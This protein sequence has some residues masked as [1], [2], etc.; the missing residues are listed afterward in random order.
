MNR[1]WI[2]LIVL[3]TLATPLTAAEPRA[4][5]QRIDHHLAQHWKADK[6]QPAPLADDAE[7]LRRV[8]LDLTGRIPLPRD[9]HDFLAD[10]DPD[11]R[12]QLVDDLLD[13]PRHS[14]HFA[15][16]WRA[17]LIPEVAAS[18][19][20]RV[21]Q[22][23]FEAWLNQKLRANVSFDQVVKELLSTPI[24]VEQ[25]SP[26]SVLKHPERPN[27]LAF[28]A[29]KDASPA[30][31]AA[32]TTRLFLGIQIECAQCHDHPFASW[33]RE[34]F[35]NQAAFFAG[36]ERQ[37]DGIFAPLSEAVERRE[38]A[39]ADSK[40]IAKALFLD[41]KSPEWK[42]KTSPR[43]ALAAWITT[44]E[45][46]YF[47]K[48]TVNRLWGQLMGRGIV[49]PVDDFNDENKPSH[50]ELLDE[51]AQAFVAAKFD[52][53]FMLRAI[54]LSEAYQRSS[55]R[56][57]ASQDEPR[58]FAKM[59]VKGL[60]GEQF[61]DNLALATGYRESPNDRGFGR[62]RTTIRTQF[63]E[64]FA[65]RGKLSDPETSIL[66][67]LTLM[68]GKFINDATTLAKSPTLTAICEMPIA[69]TTQKIDS[70]YLI[71]FSR[72]PTANEREKLESYVSRNGRAEENRRL[73]DVFWMLLNS[74]EFRLNH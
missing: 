6:V 53:R 26:E 41:Q 21:F 29:V 33:S 61:F 40:K 28:F 34:Q 17:L 45:N 73:S 10:K 12:R 57:H 13:S 8:Y 7:F 19:E 46:P 50:P 49:E 14:T 18:A 62:E 37:G 66:Q 20:A 16:V 72:K 11:K 67:A 55:V 63:L 27:P 44:A 51:L 1:F 56:S 48:A 24:A 68:N 32:T 25:Q 9:V 30:N 52:V 64:Q 43:V 4:L 35:W 36:I 42:E 74:A 70:L 65:P 23:G 31:L 3:V 2:N 15:N 58:H 59:T 71:T 5:A 47:A 22:I 38:I 69:T 39:I 60:S 54:C